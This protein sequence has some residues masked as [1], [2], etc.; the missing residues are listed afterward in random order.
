MTNADKFKNIFGLYATELWSMPEKDFLKWLN[1]EATNCS[2]ISNSSDTIS[3]QDALDALDKRFDSIPM[4]QTSEILMLRKDLREL[5]SAQPERL[6]DDDFETIRIHL[7]ACKERLCN[8][9]RW[10]E[11]EEYQRIID[12]FMEFASE[13]P[14]HEELDF[15]QPH[16]KIDVRLEIGQPEPQWIPCS[17]RLPEY[18]MCRTLTTINTH[19]KSGYYYK[20]LFYNDNG[21]TWKVTD[22]EVIAWMPLPEPYK[23][24]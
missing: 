15:V 14:E 5:P 6:T 22:K 23:G 11:A 1:S 12:R 7:S 21:D 8:Q 20:G 24:E 4:E 19:V 3:R 9:H 17:E 18:D 16:K 10:K 13:Q 2:E